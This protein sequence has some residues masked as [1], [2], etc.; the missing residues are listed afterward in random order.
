[1][2]R[3]TFIF[4]LIS[5]AASAQ[6][7]VM[8]DGKV[9][10]P[11]KRNFTWLEDKS[12]R[13]NVD[14]V[15]QLK[16]Q[17]KFLQWNGGTAFNKG[18]NK[19]IYWLY[20]PVKNITN[21]LQQAV[22]KITAVTDSAWLY[23]IDSSNKAKLLFASSRYQP[24]NERPFPYRQ[25]AFPLQ[26]QAGETRQLLLRADNR[27][28]GIYLP[29]YIQSIEK[30][31]LTEKD[32]HWMY[33]V[34]FGVFIFIILFNI[35][36]FISLKDKI[37]L[38]Y[39]AYVLAGILF[40][41][42]DERFYTELYPDSWL[43]YFENLWAPPFSLLMIATGLRVMQLF[44]DQTKQNSKL[45]K[46]AIVMIISCFVLS[47]VMFVLSTFEPQQV[48]PL[49]KKLYLVTDIFF[50]LS[51]IVLIA[52]LVEKIRDQ[53]FMALY[54]LIAVLFMVLGALNFYLNHLGVINTNILQPNGIVVGLTFEVVFLSFLLTI[55]YNRLRKEKEQL[56]ATQQQE[57]AQAM[58]QSQE[59]ER[60]RLAKD[61]H[62]GVGGKVTGINLL[63]QNYFS[64]YGTTDDAE[65]IYRT[66]LLNNIK[67][68]SEE[69]RNISHDLMPKDIQISGLSASVTNLIDTLNQG[70]NKTLFEFI[71]QGDIDSIGKH[72]Q[73]NIYRIINELVQN[74][75]KHAEAGKATIQCLLYGDTLH[76]LVE[77]NGKGFKAEEPNMGIGINNV[78]SRTNYMGGKMTI[79]SGIMG[80]T[81]LIEIPIN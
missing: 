61:L 15:V 36:L 32:R 22:L 34:Y 60:T 64:K 50:P 2:I 67:Q 55:R 30:L 65:N 20:I 47:G 31:L 41:I 14:E 39:A 78:K 5:I 16:L 3:L 9:F 21:E 57:L 46:P 26:L 80:T 29:M 53:K 40:M 49:L 72:K 58:I 17:N 13:L 73:I 81:F 56:K 4:C 51:I 54:Y 63:V 23:E 70:N 77:D 48:L 59:N 38:W 79:D 33:G 35:S 75:I 10:P 76:L 8:Y 68:T 7:V 25:F 52:S 11:I 62:D 27:S 6:D 74:I 1:M 12:G 42:Q 19:N 43:W 45:Y 44:V 69:L 18:V 24:F 37:H 66:K 28:R 71:S